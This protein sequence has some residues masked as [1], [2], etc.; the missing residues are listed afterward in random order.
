M[1]LNTLIDGHQRKCSVQA[2]MPE[3]PSVQPSG[4]ICLTYTVEARLICF[5]IFT[6]LDENHLLGNTKLSFLVLWFKSYRPC[7]QRALYFSLF[8]DSLMKITY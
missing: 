4:V 3:R 5:M 1:K 8:L 7:R 2:K 6:F